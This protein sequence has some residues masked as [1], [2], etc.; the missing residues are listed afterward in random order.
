LAGSFKNL[1]GSIYGNTSPEHNSVIEPFNLNQVR[2]RSIGR[3]GRGGT[4]AEEVEE[5]RS[6]GEYRSENFRC[7]HTVRS[8]EMTPVVATILG[9]VL[10]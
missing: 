6:Q 9:Y 7:E 10:G 3:G 2:P 8:S 5:A 1:A 4:E